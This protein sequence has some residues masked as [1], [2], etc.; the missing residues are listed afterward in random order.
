MMKSIN[1][2]LFADMKQSRKSTLRSL[3]LAT[4][5]EYDKLIFAA[6]LSL[7]QLNILELHFRQEFSICEIAE[8]LSCSESGVRK[9]LSAAYDKLSKL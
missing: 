8:K 5:T 2:R 7:L 9:K 4:R 3:L 6:N 1:P